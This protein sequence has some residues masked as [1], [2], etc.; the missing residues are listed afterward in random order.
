MEIVESGLRLFG[1]NQQLDKAGSQKHAKKHLK[2][3]EGLHDAKSVGG[4]FRRWRRRKEIVYH[5]KI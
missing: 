2:D 4:D 3:P 5:V 1:R